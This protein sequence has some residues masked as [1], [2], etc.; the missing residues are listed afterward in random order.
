MTSCKTKQDTGL[1]LYSHLWGKSGTGQY[2]DSSGF[3]TLCIDA[4]V[5]FT[6]ALFIY[7]Y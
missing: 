6:Y 7:H 2:G 3:G 4:R 1:R 5:D